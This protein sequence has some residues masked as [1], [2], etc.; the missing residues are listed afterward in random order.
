MPG[1]PFYSSAFWRDLRAAAL[2]R[3][4][5]I[6]AAPGCTKRAVF[7]DHI[8]SRPPVPHPCA[9]DTLTNLRSLCASHDAQVKEARKGSSARRSRGHFR[10]IGCDVDGWPVDPMRRDGMG[11]SDHFELYPVTGPGR[12]PQRR[13]LK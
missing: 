5:G 8:V 6:C 3:D 4:R 1:N 10:V 7:V 9:A 2:K 12:Y 11:V 13:N